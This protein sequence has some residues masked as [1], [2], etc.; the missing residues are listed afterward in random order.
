MKKL[1]AALILTTGF[2]AGAGYAQGTAA[3]SE[4]TDMTAA[5]A[6]AAS[7]ETV[8]V[9]AQGMGIDA[10]SALRNAYSNAIQQALGL[11]VDAETLVQNDQIIKDQVLTHS[12]GLIQEVTTVSQ[13]SQDGIYNVTVR[14]KVLRQPLIEKVK[15]ILKATTTLDGTSLHAAIA[16]EQQQ[17]KD[18]QAMLNEAIKPFI[19]SELFD[20][21]ITGNPKSQE[22][23]KETL[24]V[25]VQITPN[26][27][28][29]KQA[30]QNLITVLDQIAVKKIERSIDLNK[31]KDGGDY[32]Y[33]NT[34]EIEITSSTKILK[35]ILLNDR[36]DNVI[37]VNTWRSKNRI[38]SKWSIYVVRAKCSPPSISSQIDVE[39]L[40]ESME[41]LSFGFTSQEQGFSM[42]A[43]SWGSCIISPDFVASRFGSQDAKLEPI[44]SFFT[45][46]SIEE[47]LLPDAKSVK[48]SIKS[49]P[50]ETN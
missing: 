48:I 40:N 39:I 4:I 24:L 41:P 33:E 46:V 7:P 15:P 45:P 12:R 38:Q 21:K 16:T 49:E 23:N 29:Y 6:S 50:A 5:R 8:D 30:I 3:T 44:K 9:V 10:D 11:Y 32:F 17:T 18:A 43:K 28:R 31:I 34:G 26:L 2:Y 27:D 35:D 20:A 22:G 42:I 36:K 1:A 25:P 19:G 37:L 47:S 14:A 13:G